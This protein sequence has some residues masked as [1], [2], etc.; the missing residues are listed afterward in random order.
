MAKRKTTVKKSAEKK[1]SLKKSAVKKSAVK[2]GAEDK[3]EVSI[4][5][6]IGLRFKQFREALGKTQ[7]ELARELEIYQSTI[8]NI[9]VGKTFP[10][11]KYMR[12]LGETYRLN[13]DWLVN[14]R[15]EM[16]QNTVLLPGA[17]LERYSELL[18]LMQVPVV[19]QLILARLQE[20]KAIASEDI[21]RYQSQKP[22][23]GDVKGER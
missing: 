10:G 19:E 16:Y 14:R 4:K 15:G 8:T 21:K 3:G 5:K 1:D 22:K 13:A 17:V 18:G 6:E 20:V 9:E 12:Y 7:V 23:P 2:K 11:H